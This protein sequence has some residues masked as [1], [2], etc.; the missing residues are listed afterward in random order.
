[1]SD[2]FIQLHRHPM[3]AKQAGLIEKAKEKGMCNSEI[4]ELLD[5]T[6]ADHRKALSE[7]KTGLSHLQESR[8]R[9]RYRNSAPKTAQIA[10]QQAN[11][12]KHEQSHMKNASAQSEASQADF[13]D[14]AAALATARQVGAEM[15]RKKA[16]A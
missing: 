7:V 3:A 11:R 12:T 2:K 15:G 10:T 13:I 16:S 6:H 9:G 4:W 1:M 14:P 5:A 8:G